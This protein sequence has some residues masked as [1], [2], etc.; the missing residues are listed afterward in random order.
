[1]TTP[2]E[3]AAHIAELLHLTR[4]TN[5][6]SDSA[7]ELSAATLNQPAHVLAL[8]LLEFSSGLLRA[9]KS[10]LEIQLDCANSQKAAEEGRLQ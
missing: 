2:T 10:V 9:S 4:S 6:T 1:M 7:L 5:W 3:T 8:A